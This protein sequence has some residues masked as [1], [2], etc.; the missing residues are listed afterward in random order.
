MKIFNLFGIL[1]NNL[2]RSSIIIIILLFIGSILEMLGIGLI[3][4]LLSIITNTGNQN[5]Y[6]EYLNFIFQL[7]DPSQSQL[8]FHICILI[9]LIFIFKNIFLLSINFLSL[10]FVKKFQ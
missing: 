2:K 7:D 8:I 1:G 10:K 5:K 6:T 9:L 4:P 3:F